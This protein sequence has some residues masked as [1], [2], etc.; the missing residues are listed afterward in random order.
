MKNRQVEH[1][2]TAGKV[3]ELLYPVG[4]YPLESFL[5]PSPHER[6]RRAIV[7]VKLDRSEFGLRPLE[8]VRHAFDL[9]RRQ[10]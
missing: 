9:L 1:A 2:E 10:Q 7:D 5:D 4:Y 3:E 8:A 6:T